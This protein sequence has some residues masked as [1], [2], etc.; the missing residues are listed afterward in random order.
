MK[1]L[2]YNLFLGTLSNNGDTVPAIVRGDVTLRSQSLD[3]RTQQW[4][5]DQTPVRAAL[6]SKEAFR[7]EHDSLDDRGVIKTLSLPP[8]I[9]GMAFDSIDHPQAGFHTATRTLQTGPVTFDELRGVSFE[10][11]D[12]NGQAWSAMA[13]QSPIIYAKGMDEVIEI[14]GEP[15]PN[16]E[17]RV[18]MRPTTRRVSNLSTLRELAGR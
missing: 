4:V 18:F 1:S 5:D 8:E 11:T 3:P 17:I 16:A 6:R 10:F 9:V 15:A 7:L 2:A 13:I 12:L 14:D